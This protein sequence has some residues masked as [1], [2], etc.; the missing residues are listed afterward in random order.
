MFIPRPRQCQ[1]SPPISSLSHKHCHCRCTNIACSPWPSSNHSSSESA[2]GKLPTCHHLRLNHPR[3][4]SIGS[5]EAFRKQQL[6]STPR[7]TFVVSARAITRLRLHP[8]VLRPHPSVI[9]PF[10]QKPRKMCAFL[11]LL[12]CA[13]IRL[14][15]PHRTLRLRL[16][17]CAIRL[18]PFNQKPRKKC[19]CVRPLLCALIR[20]FHPRC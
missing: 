8:C 4:K 5:T 11:R 18:R 6:Q 7:R 17:P 12:L 16:H 3:A 19:V 9:R 2:H 14:F 20:S 1:T 13:L 10:N 15:H